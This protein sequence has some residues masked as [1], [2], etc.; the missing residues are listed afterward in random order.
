MH[1][2]LRA[3]LEPVLRDVR[4]ASDLTADID[5]SLADPDDGEQPWVWFRILRAGTR[6]G[7]DPWGVPVENVAGIAEEVQDA[8]IETYGDR[9]T[10]RP[11]PACPLHQQKHKLLV[12]IV[13]DPAPHAAW[14]C[15][16][17]GGQREVS[18][19]GGLSGLR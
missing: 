11:W 7:V 13:E 8:V 16:R 12:A 15:T 18:E 4:E 9:G 14:V 10:P 5:E 17:E 19:V 3:A 2:A 6:V 1:D